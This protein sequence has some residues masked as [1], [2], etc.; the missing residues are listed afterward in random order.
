M[1]RLDEVPR[2]LMVRAGI[3][4]LRQHGTRAVKG[5]P[6][7]VAVVDL[8]GVGSTS[9]CAICKELGID[10]GVSIRDTLV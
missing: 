3:R 4:L 10:P 8:C 7:W 9:A 5:A 6:V 1:K 2:D